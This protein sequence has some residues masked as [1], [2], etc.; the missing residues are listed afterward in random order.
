MRRSFTGQY[1]RVHDGAG[2]PHGHGRVWARRLR[3]STRTLA[4]R[5]TGAVEINGKKFLHREILSPFSPFYVVESDFSF[6]KFGHGV[7]TCIGRHI[8][9]LEMGKFVPQLLRQMDVEWAGGVQNPE[10]KTHC[11]FLFKQTHM[12]VKFTVR[13]RKEEKD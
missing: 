11:N 13:D 5:F 7:R 10:W 2:H 4:R 12:P 9:T 1:Q 8:S 3:I 6:S